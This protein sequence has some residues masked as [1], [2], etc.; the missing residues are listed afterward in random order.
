MTAERRLRFALCLQGA[1]KQNTKV[2]KDLMVKR[3]PIR[4][5]DGNQNDHVAEFVPVEK[6]FYPYRVAVSILDEWFRAHSDEQGLRDKLTVS[7]LVSARAYQ[8]FQ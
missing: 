7:G 6:K 8:C 3:G 4:Y 5:R 2:P 1:E